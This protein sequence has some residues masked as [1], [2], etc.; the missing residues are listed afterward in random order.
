F[1][2]AMSFSMPLFEVADIM[3]QVNF[4]GRTFSFNCNLLE[5]IER[6]IRFITNRRDWLKA[7]YILAWGNAL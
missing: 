3:G 1:Y 2:P 7:K 4:M 5:N 6:T